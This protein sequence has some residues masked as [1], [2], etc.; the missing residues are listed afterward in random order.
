MERDVA[1]TG[2]GES[3]D[4]HG[5]AA[6]GD[7]VGSRG[8]TGDTAGYAIGDGGRCSANKHGRNSCGNHDWA[9]H[10]RR[11]AVDKAADGY[12][13]YAQRGSRRHQC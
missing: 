7:P 9:T 1:Q 8:G 11:G 6:L 3:P 10:V 4:V 5:C 12:I 2:R 13:P